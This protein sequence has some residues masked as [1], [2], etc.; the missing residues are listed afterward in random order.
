M[1]MKR[2]SLAATF[3]FLAFVV[4]LLVL[5]RQSK[6]GTPSSESRNEDVIFGKKFFFD[7][8][9]NVG[10]GV[11]SITGTLAGDGVGY[12]NNTTNISCYRDRMECLV[13]LV[14]QIGAHQIGRLESP[15]FYQITKWSNFEVVSVSDDPCVKITINL[16]RKS[17][18]ALWVQEPSNQTSAF[19]KDSD[20][21]IHKW[22]IENSLYW[23]AQRK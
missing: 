9:D 4:A 21:K 3:W 7:S 5:I 14:E 13:T 2:P 20:T 19:C 6:T 22:T 23:Q 10:E 16:E 15:A 1:M 12:K 8:A 11:V 17:E 18:T